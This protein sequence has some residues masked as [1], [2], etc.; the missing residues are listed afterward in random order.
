MLHA[1]H[2][3][4]LKAPDC[5]RTA[6]WYVAAFAFV[7]EDDA[8]RPTGDRFIRCRSLAG[9]TVNISEARPG[10]QMNRS[11]PDAHWGL[12]HF[13]FEV[14][15]IHAEIT[16]LEK[17]GATLIEGPTMA[18]TGR[19]IAFLRGPDDIRLELVEVASPVS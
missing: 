17:L 7:I 13:G 10:E 5:R 8:I 11:D 18:R 3:I 6:E 1:I 4:H 9:L 15:D 14:Y 19:H 12:E 16:R 2:H